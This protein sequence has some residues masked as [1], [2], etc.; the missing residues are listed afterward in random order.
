[1]GQHLIYHLGGGKGGIEH[2]IDHIGENKRRLWND[3]AAWTTIP[4]EAKE[5]LS[6]GIEEEVQ[7]KTIEELAHWRNEKLVGLLQQIYGDKV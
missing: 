2:F 7:G 5:V 3:M 6:K 4:D 1:M